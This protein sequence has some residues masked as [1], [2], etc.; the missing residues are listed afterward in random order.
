MTFTVLAFS[1]LGHVLAIRSERESL[2]AQGLRSNLPLLGAVVLTVALQMAAIYV[3]AL[4]SL[5]NTTALDP[6]E[7]AITLALSMVVFVL[8]EL[9]KYLVRCNLIYRFRRRSVELA[10]KRA[11]DTENT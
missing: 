10:T 2:F 11:A 6:A 5:L 1:Q 4:S 7:L 9:E 3:P 8:V